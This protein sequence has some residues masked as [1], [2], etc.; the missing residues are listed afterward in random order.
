MW[1]GYVL[2]KSVDEAILILSE[3]Q[4][5]ARIIAGGTDLVIQLKEKARSAKCL[6]DITRIQELERIC[7]DGDMIVIG[8]AVTHHQVASSDCIR[9]HAAVLAEAAQVVGSPQIRRTGTIVGNIVNAQ[10]AADTAVALVALRAE[11]QIASQEGRAWVPVEELFVGPGTS[12]VDSTRQLIT[13]VRLP[14]LH[15]LSGSAFERIARRK[16]LSLPILNAAVVLTLDDR[17]TTCQDASICLAPVAPVPFRAV[18]AESALRG[19]PLDEPSIQAALDAAMAEARPRS[20]ILRASREYRQVMVRVL[21]RRA[22]DRAMTSARRGG[23][24]Q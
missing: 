17:G 12:S 2:A 14:A 10:P 6:V 19:Q 5:D 7:L 13:A 21:L 18:A 4:G 8:A 23:S 24:C 3:Y 9:R 22:I 15:G 20:N 11:A 16:A 1:Q